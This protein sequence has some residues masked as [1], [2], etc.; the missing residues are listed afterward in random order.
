MSTKFVLTH[1]DSTGFVGHVVDGSDVR[2]TLS[3]LRTQDIKVLGVYDTQARYETMLDDARLRCS[4]HDRG[5]GEYLCAGCLEKR[6]AQSVAV[7]TAIRA[8]ERAA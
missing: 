7:M 4:A 2:A 8:A 3:R 1:A 6:L 5:R